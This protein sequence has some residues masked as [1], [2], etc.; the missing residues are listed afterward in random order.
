M[1]GCVSNL[2]QIIDYGEEGPWTSLVVTNLDSGW[3]WAGSAEHRGPLSS[4]W[5]DKL[6]WEW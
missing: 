4:T 2:A 6:Y 1:Q 3:I 5:W